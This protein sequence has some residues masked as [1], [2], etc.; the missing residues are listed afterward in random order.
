MVGILIVAHSIYGEALVRSVSHVLGQ[1]P[2]RVLQ[3]GMTVRDDPDAMLGRAR[4]ALAQ[5]DDGHGVLVLTDIL[6]ATPSNIA[7]RLARPEHVAVI[8]GVNLPMLVRALTYRNEPLDTV[9]RKA[10]SGG[11]E[12]VM[13]VEPEAYHAAGRS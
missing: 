1:A 8:A 3:L 11:R 13:Q 2:A 12:G 6:G 9:V 10:L 4:E 5:L 7:T